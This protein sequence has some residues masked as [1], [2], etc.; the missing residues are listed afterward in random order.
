MKSAL[1]SGIYLIVIRLTETGIIFGEAHYNLN[2]ATYYVICKNII[3]LQANASV[4][5]CITSYVWNQNILCEKLA[6]N[7]MDIPFNNSNILCV[8]MLHK[9]VHHETWF[10]HNHVQI[11]ADIVSV[12]YVS[13]YH[14]I[15]FQC[16]S[17]VN[18]LYS[19]PKLSTSWMSDSLFLANG[20]S[21]LV[22]HFG[23]SYMTDQNAVLTTP[24]T[25]SLQD[26]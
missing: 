18:L 8:I 14:I 2:L 23:N 13:S 6:H 22:S 10:K 1:K 24:V 21:L 25:A 26:E 16:T 7:T 9:M 15:S 3:M 11:Q 5:W 12:N 19:L 20:S 17:E 4:I